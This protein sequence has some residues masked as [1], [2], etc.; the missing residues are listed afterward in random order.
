[1]GHIKQLELTS[2][3]SYD[4][5]TLSDIPCGFV[6]LTG[7][8]GAGK[9]NVLE[10]ISLVTNSRGLRQC[11]LTDAQRHDDLDPLAIALTL[12]D[13]Y[14][15]Q[16][17]GLGLD[18]QR[19]KK[20][21]RLNGES[22]RSYAQFQDYMR[23][24]W[25]TPQMDGLFLQSAGERRRFFDRLVASFDPAHQG[26]MARYDKALSQRSKLLKD[27][28]QPDPVWLGGLET[29]MAET[30]LAVAAARI[31]HLHRLRDQWDHV[32][33][34]DLPFPKALLALN[35]FAETRLNETDQAAVDIED[36]LRQHYAATRMRDA[37]TGGAQDGAHKCDLLV[38]YADKNIPAAQCS[39][40][41]Q[42]ALLIG[43]I[44]ANAAIL[45][46]LHDQSPILLLDEVP[47]HLDQ[48]R[49]GALF[50]LLHSLKAQ[51]WISATD[52]EIFDHL[53]AKS[54]ENSMHISVSQGRLDPLAF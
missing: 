36:E 18:P 7:P 48:N 39:T 54:R 2:F 14:G 25:L 13:D 15:D 41:E 28:R 23:C 37:I 32:I 10:A 12:H 5:V 38:S 34:K 52:P 4:S 19:I 8:N 17:L 3:R 9:T 20:I 46:A 47:A 26:R 11:P 31:D 30:S 24:V 21:L 27:E 45:N 22:A 53:P 50:D 42:K 1:M 29:Q 40:G 6:T 51:I 16:R 49:R 44:L 43:L 33:P 35:G